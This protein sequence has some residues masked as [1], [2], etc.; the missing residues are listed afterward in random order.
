MTTVG[1]V[2]TQGET[3]E[4]SLRDALFRGLAPDGGLYMPSRL[5]RL[6]TGDLTLLRGMGWP[7]VATFLA[8][9]LLAGALEGDA[10]ESVVRRAL[11]FPLPVV[12]LTKRIRVLD[13]SRGPTLAF[14]DVGARFMARLMDY[15]RGDESGPLT[16]LTA[17]SGDT[18]GAVAHAFLGLRGIRVVV[19][20][21]EGKVSTRQERQF[22]TLGENV[23]AVAV[24]GD[25]DDCQRMAKDAFRDPEIRGAV[26]LSSA[27]SINI[28]RFLPQSFYFVHAWGEIR[29]R[30]EEG[31]EA[32]GPA[33]PASPILF[34]VPSGNF[35][36]LAAG[37]T[38]SAMGL[39]DVTFLAATNANDVVPRLLKTGRFQPR[40]SLRTLST[41][42]DVGNPSNLARI[43]HL[44]HQDL[45]RLRRDLTGTSVTD[46]ETRD[47]IRRVYQEYGH[48]LDPH[49][50]VGFAALE[51][52][53]DR[54]SDATGVLLATA[55]PAK[56]AEV[57]EPILG[58]SLPVPE[59]LARGLA[60]ERRVMPMAPDSIALKDFLMA[61]D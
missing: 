42:M 31:P 54:R 58:V 61:Q 52:E 9:L 35:G 21:P 53:L 47:T 29:S 8:R 41:A 34:S 19:L 27:N 40:P 55:S 26:S 59:A 1:Y 12:R 49:T 24:Q 33:S 22:S 50:A 56:F 7:G 30:R 57:V 14:K 51:R 13:L 37:L 38:A 10:A 16:I 3:P 2:S 48:V 15:F 23:Q 20:F 44:Y 18:G 36:N 43:L 25:F 39:P 32:P 17:T 5:P 6:S 60:A 28:G 4:T 45:N 11:D 46:P